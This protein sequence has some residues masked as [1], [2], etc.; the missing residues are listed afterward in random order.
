LQAGPRRFNELRGDL[1]TVSAKV[2]ASHLRRLEGAGLVHRE[3]RPTSPPTVEYSLT[4][5]GQQLKP[6]LEL[7][8]QV[9]HAV[10]HRAPAAK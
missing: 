2:L 3:L 9:G 6:A 7:L 4:E 8:L 10:A 1:R 5:L